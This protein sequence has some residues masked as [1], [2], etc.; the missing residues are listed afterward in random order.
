MDSSLSTIKDPSRGTTDGP[1]FPFDEVTGKRYYNKKIASVVSGN[2][3]FSSFVGPKILS[4]W[5]I[6]VCLI[7]LG[8]KK[9]DD[10]IDEKTR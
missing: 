3:S 1:N 10:K 2:H 6:L 8:G 9:T 7:S 5:S 4:V